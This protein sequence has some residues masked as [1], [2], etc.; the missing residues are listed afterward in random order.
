MG[1]SDLHLYI[2][3]PGRRGT[4]LSRMNG[5]VNGVDGVQ[6]GDE[7]N[8]NLNNNEIDEEILMEMCKFSN[9]STA[10]NVKKASGNFVMRVNGGN[11]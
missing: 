1:K 11:L 6:D 2:N 7:A 10:N 4:E 3:K 5:D 9:M 8:R